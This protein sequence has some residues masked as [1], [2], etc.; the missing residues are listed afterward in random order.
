MVSY[1]IGGNSGKKIELKEA[2]DLVA[3]R[4]KNAQSLQ[5]IKLSKASRSMLNSMVRV[6]SFPEANVNVYRVM[7]T[8]QLSDKKTR[9]AV[10]KSMGKEPEVR[11][12]GRTLI[13]KHGIIHMYTGNM[14][15]KF[16]EH[17]PRETCIDYLLKNSL[18][19]KKE[20]VYAKNAFFVKGSEGLGMK[21][22]EISER[23]LES[24]EIEFC[25]P[26]LIRQ[27]K[28]KFVPQI[29]DR[30]WHL[31]D[32]II[33][34][35]HIHAHIHVKKAWEISQGQGV[36]IAVIDDGVDI[37]HPEFNLEEKIVSPRNMNPESDDPRPVYDSDSHGTACAGVACAAGINKAAGVAPKAKLMPIR[38]STNL[39]SMYEAEAFVYAANNGA[40]IISCS[41]GPPDGKWY[42]PDDLRH[43]TPVPLFDST[44]LAIEYALE[45]GRE[46]K[47]CCITWAAGNGRESVSFDGYA[48]YSGIICVS[49]SNDRDRKSVYSDFGE[50]VSCCFPSSDQGYSLFQHPEPISPGIWTTDNAGKEG[51]N[52]GSSIEQWHIGDKEGDYRATFGGTSS[53][54]PGVAGVI[55]LMLSVNPSLS[56][57]Q[58]KELIKISC[59]KIDLD[60]GRYDAQGHSIYYGYG[61]INAEKA[62]VNAK[63]LLNTPL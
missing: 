30:Q 55:A 45:H 46:G 58:V 12:A 27:K 18:E 28:N 50:N 10:R 52:P 60:H 40:D 1:K 15:I 19:I 47:G 17:I 43:S 57:Q 38:N 36:I 4:L 21:I 26:E 44:R 41:W 39:G 31:K 24:E 34:E 2:N 37:D 42:D 49:A 16:K 23:L 33:N 54:A 32:T 63:S 35:Q 22:F 62:V 25:H 7:G 59:D 9:N 56:Y 48:N 20:V 8:G 51:A 3:I 53:S 14:F 13:D 11:F 5:E 61:K 29:F 6:A